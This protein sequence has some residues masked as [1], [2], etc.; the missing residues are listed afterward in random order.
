MPSQ[1][2]RWSCIPSGHNRTS[3]LLRSHLYRCLGTSH[4]QRT[5]SEGTTL[6]SH[7]PSHHSFPFVTFT[8]TLSPDRNCCTAHNNHAWHSPGYKPRG[9]T[10]SLVSEQPQSAAG[11]LLESLRR[12]R[13]SLCPQ[14]CVPVW[15]CAHLPSL[16]C[17]PWSVEI[18]QQPQRLGRGT[19]QLPI[20]KVLLTGSPEEIFPHLTLN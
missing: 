19:Q 13:T 11:R 7:R 2:T 1:A 6:R 14:V 8:G 20:L 3:V 4:P 10:S 5:K 16:R 18:T 15:V 12:D 17:F 9:I